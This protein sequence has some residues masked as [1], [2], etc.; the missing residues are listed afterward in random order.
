MGDALPDLLITGELSDGAIEALA[1]LLVEAA[2][3][4]KTNTGSERPGAGGATVGA[5]EL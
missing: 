5:Q 2:E 3:N 1:A 4:E